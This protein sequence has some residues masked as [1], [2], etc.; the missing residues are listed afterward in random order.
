LNEAI[1]DFEELT[2]RWL[3]PWEKGLLCVAGGALGGAVIHSIFGWP[4][5]R[6][7]VFVGVGVVLLHKCY[8]YFF[9]DATNVVHDYS[10][11]ENSHGDISVLED[12]HYKTE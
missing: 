7:V 3:F 10:I 6:S 2:K 11:H 12:G 1:N 8:K 5:V 4:G 9:G